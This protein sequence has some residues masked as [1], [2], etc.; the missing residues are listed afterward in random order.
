MESIKLKI[1]N[2]V[3]RSS[4]KHILGCDINEEDVFNF[5]FEKCH[6]CGENPSLHSPVTVDGKRIKSPVPRNG[7]D[8]K[9]SDIGY[10]KDNCVTC[11]TRCNYMKREIGYDD[12]ISLIKTINGRIN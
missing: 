5:I 4:S 7:I 8:R 12:F 10:F 9:Y 3:F 2:E 1:A 11:C 6:Y